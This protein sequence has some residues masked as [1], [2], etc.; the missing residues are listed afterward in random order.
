MTDITPSDSQARAIA[1]IRD[2][3]ESRTGEQQVFRLFGYAGSGKST[4][5]KFALDELGLEP[6]SADRDGGTCMPGVVTA[7]FTGKAALV[8]RRKGTPA[9]T[10]HSLIYSVIEATEEE[11]AEAQKKI[12][13]AENEACRLSG[14]DRI[15][16]DAGIEA[17]R[18]ALAAM[19]KPRF[20]LNPQS[21][22]AEARL[23]VLDEVSM[24]G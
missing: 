16:A 10:I 8:L 18:Q 3:F 14:F 20:A 13:Q 17:M 12:A 22:A 1:E 4:V 2:W 21:D 24:V 5:L 15:T 11:I 9:R 19:K 7:T 23:I 6:H